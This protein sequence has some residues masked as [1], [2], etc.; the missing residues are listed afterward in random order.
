MA[1]APT[2]LALARVLPGG[3][4]PAC[5]IRRL[6]TGRA[7]RSV[8]RDPVRGA[9]VPRVLAAGGGRRERSAKPRLGHVD[10]RHEPRDVVGL[11]RD[12]PR[13]GRH[14][15]E[16]P[17]GADGGLLPDRGR[18]ARALR[19]VRPNAPRARDGRREWRERE[20]EGRM[21]AHDPQPAPQESTDHRFERAVALCLHAYPQRWRAVRS[22]ELT[23]VLA[24][25]AGPSPRR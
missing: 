18:R 4:A 10:L 1:W 6:G 20:S 15:D 7:D 9:A 23:A 21:T 24:D 14:A 2:V 25:L 8:D 22:A 11:V 5:A 16:R 3:P 12:S 19:A 13:P 17:R